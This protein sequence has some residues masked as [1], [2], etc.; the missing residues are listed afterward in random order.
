MDKM[1]IVIADDEKK[2]CLLLRNLIDWDSI[3]MEIVGE[4]NNGM[5]A[6]QLLI[7]ERPDI[8]ILDIRMPGMDGLELLQKIREMD[9]S[10]KVILISGHKHFEY[11]HTALRYGVE[12]YLLKPISGEE[13]MNN[14]QM[15]KNKILQESGE[16]K[17]RMV[18]EERLVES[19]E[20]VRRN[21]LADLV[22]N[23]IRTE[24]AQLERWNQE[25]YLHLQNGHFRIGL[26]QV[27]GLKRQQADIVLGYTGSFLENSFR[28]FNYELLYLKDKHTL[29]CLFNYEKEEEW[30][31]GLRDFLEKLVQKYEDVCSFNIG[32]SKESGSISAEMLGQAR[33]AALYFLRTG[34]HKII[35]YTESMERQENFPENEWYKKL[36]QALQIESTELVEK[37]FEILMKYAEKR[38]MSPSTLYGVMNKAG[39]LLENSNTEKKLE[40]AVFVKA[41]YL[42]CLSQAG[43]ERELVSTG[44]KEALRFIRECTELRERKDSKY[45]RLAKTY[46]ESNFTRDLLLEDTAKEIG[47]NSSYLS[48]LFKKEQGITF[49]DYLTEVRISKAKEMLEEGRMTVSEVGWAVGYKDQKYFSKLFL[50]VVGIKPSEYKK[51]YS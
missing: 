51:L 32:I 48:A 25:Y 19:V 8:V 20:K 12:N 33:D 5:D 30:R 17:R 18:M 26:L 16:V 3:G 9:E 24:Q 45:V 29:I 2:I 13:L 47:I 1:K 21:F 42:E 49:T 4:A 44:K 10:I 36:Q 7:A 15:V 39:Q 28:S 50:K 40:A 27:R 31:E 41:Q 23:R 11:A 46:I 43:T 38:I 35:F 34:M 22:D 6:L 14:L 37:C